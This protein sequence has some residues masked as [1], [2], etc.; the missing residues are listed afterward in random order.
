LAAGVVATPK[1]KSH[2][3]TELLRLYWQIGQDIL[4]RQARQG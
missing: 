3:N 4:D 1:P 2:L